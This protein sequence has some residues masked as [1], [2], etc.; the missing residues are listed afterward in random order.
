MR[1]QAC[2]RGV[3]TKANTRDRLELQVYLSD[4][5]RDAALT[6]APSASAEVCRSPRIV[7]RTEGPCSALPEDLSKPL[8]K[9]LPMSSPMRT[10]LAQDAESSQG[11]LGSPA[12]SQMARAA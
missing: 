2:Q 7:T 9:S 8:Q 12:P 5:S 11:G 3:D 4:C 10:V 6:A 1:D